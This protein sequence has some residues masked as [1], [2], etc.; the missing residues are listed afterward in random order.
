MKWNLPALII[1][2]V[3]SLVGVNGRFFSIQST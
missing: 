1:V 3:L 2:D